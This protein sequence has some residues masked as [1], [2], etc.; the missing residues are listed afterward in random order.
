[1]QAGGCDA[2]GKPI[3]ASDTAGGRSDSSLGCLLEGEVDDGLV[4]MD[5]LD[6]VAV[7]DECVA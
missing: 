6:Q 4:N 3:C 2:H 5:S 7:D 1:M